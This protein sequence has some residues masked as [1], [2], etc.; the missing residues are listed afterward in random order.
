MAMAAVTRKLLLHVPQCIRRLQICVIPSDMQISFVIPAHDEADYI[1]RTI[2]AIRDAA[3]GSPYPYEIVVACDGCTDRTAEIAESL[4]ARVV[5][6]DR[7]QIAA[8]RNLGARHATGDLLI[9][10]DADTRIDRDVFTQ[11]LEAIERGAIAGGAP[12]NLDGPLTLYAR[13]LLVILGTTFRLANLAG[14][15]Y[16]FCTRAAFEAAGGW[17]ETYFAGEELRLARELERHG[18]F[19]LI[20]APILSSG[21][22][23]RTHTKGELLGLFFRGLFT[24]SVMKKRE[25]LAFF[26]GPRRKDPHLQNQV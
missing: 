19:T 20:R 17:D 21:R 5:S 24:P 4:G 10:V 3:G 16:I 8:T 23:I 13:A 9:F 7:R 22:K 11:T 2:A 26:Y 6:H 25:K 18:K 14:G 1:G 15:A 12:T